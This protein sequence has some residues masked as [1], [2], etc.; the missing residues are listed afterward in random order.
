MTETTAQ[1]AD[2]PVQL[3]RFVEELLR[4]HIVLWYPFWCVWRRH[5]EQAVE[6]RCEHING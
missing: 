5:R 3:F 4:L 1:E 2:L 6:E